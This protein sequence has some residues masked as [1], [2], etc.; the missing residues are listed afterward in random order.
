VANRLQTRSNDPERSSGRRF[1][2]AQLKGWDAAC[3]T[4]KRTSMDEDYIRAL[5]YGHVPP[6]GGERR[7]G[8]RPADIHAVSRQTVAIRGLFHSLLSADAPACLRRATTSEERTENC[9]V[10]S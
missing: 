2:R 5:E 6:T 10:Q 1:E 3:D 8:H 4:S 7:S 9:G